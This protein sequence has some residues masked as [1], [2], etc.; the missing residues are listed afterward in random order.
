MLIRTLT[1]T[2]FAAGCVRI[3]MLS[4]SLN[5][6]VSNLNISGPTR[7]Y[8]L[9]LFDGDDLPSDWLPREPWNNPERVTGGRLVLGEHG[10]YSLRLEWEEDR[11]Q[12][13]TLAQFMQDAGTYESRTDGRIGFTSMGG[14]TFEATARAGTVTVSGYTLYT[15]NTSVVGE[16]TFRD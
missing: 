12:G 8:D 14:D 15:S 5:L 1:A 9:V 11:G 13:Q 10:T 7:T 4:P 3:S 16:L 6:L 2:G